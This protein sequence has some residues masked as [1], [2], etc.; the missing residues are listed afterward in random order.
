[1]LT[2]SELIDVYKLLVHYCVR[3]SDH[4]TQ[5]EYLN[6]LQTILS[7]EEASP[8]QQLELLKV[9][10]NMAMIYNQKKMAPLCISTLNSIK[11]QFT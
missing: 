9:Q 5:L 4:D 10:R 8:S 2:Q 3:F 1:M 6:Q 11:V 7:E